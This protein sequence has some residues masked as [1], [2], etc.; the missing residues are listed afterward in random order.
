VADVDETGQVTNLNIPLP[1][2][3]KGTYTIQA[4]L[5]GD[6][7]VYLQKSFTITA[8]PPSRPTTLPA[9]AG[10]YAVP[11]SVT[12]KGVRKWVLQDVSPGGTQYIF[13]I[14]PSDMG[15]PHAESL[16]SIESTTDGSPV[17]WEAGAGLQEWEFSGYSTSQTFYVALEAFLALR[18]RFWLIDHRNR[19]WPVS[20]T[21]IEWTP[22]RNPGNDW[23]FEYTVKAQIYGEPVTP[24]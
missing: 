15:S 5:I 18:R 20:F 4:L 13:P 24:S 17:L 6:Q 14:N 7:D 8:D 11:A 21:A 19:A 1:A 2:L 9:N 3:P 23:S 12:G 10:P 16:V 22:K